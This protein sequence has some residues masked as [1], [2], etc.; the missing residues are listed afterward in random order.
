M[1]QKNYWGR[2]VVA[3]QI[4]VATWMTA[5]TV[6]V[7]QNGPQP[8]HLEAAYRFL[9]SERDQGGI[10][11]TATAGAL[12]GRQ[13]PLS[14]FDTAAY[15]G[16]HVCASEDCRVVDE[17]NPQTYAVLPRPSKAGDLQTERV[18]THNGINIYDGATWQI[19]LMLGQTHHR[20]ELPEQKDAYTLVGN[21]NLLLQQ[22]HFGDSPHP[23]NAQIRGLTAGS[24]FVYNQRPIQDPRQ[25][26][27]FRMLPRRWLAEDPFMGT[28]YAHFLSTVGLP[29]PSSEYRPGLISWTDW[30][31]I[32]GENAWAF[33]IGP[34]QAALL[35]YRV[36][37]HNNF[38]PLQD[39]AVDNALHVL[40]TFAA[41]QSPLGGV[42][43]APA[44]TVSNQGTELVDPSFISVENTISVYAGI[45]ILAHVLRTTLA[46]Q[47]ELSP[48]DRLRIEQALRTCAVME[49]GGTIDGRTTRGLRSFF[50]HQAWREGV[51]VQGG[52]A[53]KSGQPESWLPAKAIRAVDVNTWG[54][55]AI[56]AA[57][58]DRWF[59]FGAA[60]A[61]W[62]QVKA[63]GGYGQGTTLW[64]VGFSDQDGNGINADG[65]F[66]QGVLS[67]EWTFGAIT[68]VRDLIDNYQ[69]S[70]ASESL[71]GPAAHF[72]EN[73]Q[74]D[75]Q[76]MVRAM[77]HLRLD[78]YAAIP[79]PGQPAQYQRLIALPTEPTLYASRRYF[80]PFGWYANPLPSTCATSWR[81]MVA[82]RFNPFQIQGRHF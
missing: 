71:T 27:S 5:G 8:E 46:R 40:P 79:F 22:G 38:V 1:A 52:W 73:L 45:R 43:Y 66:R 12:R 82:S 2:W 36:E 68:M 19:A 34:L 15:W 21:Q 60:Y 6:C 77:D 65:R 58:I 37:R 74:R 3:I 72:V 26:F 32:T 75:E 57:T 78:N 81:I 30:K 59:G 10:L 25:A 67:G 29:L 76:S 41:M 24:V 50:R 54:I 14:Y 64:G 55:A 47:S 23:S 62:Q 69:R 4:I 48:A 80:I 53:G 28:N 18:N 42:Y 7:G 16:E 11:Y 70:M 39:L 35:H 33:L 56:G 13:V 63:W 31:P 49:Q 44:G 17:Y 51:F 9:I 61:N 20:F